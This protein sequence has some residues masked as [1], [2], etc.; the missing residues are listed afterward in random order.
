MG[1]SVK[2]ISVGIYR[3]N[4]SFSCRQLCVCVC[5]C[6]RQ[7]ITNKSQL[8]V[9][10]G[11]TMLRQMALSDL[12]GFLSRYMKHSEMEVLIPYTDGQREH[13]LPWHPMKLL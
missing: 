2:E 7:T 3:K 13:I 5:V 1:F 6:G 12:Q 11:I 8:P 10:K 9:Q 4:E